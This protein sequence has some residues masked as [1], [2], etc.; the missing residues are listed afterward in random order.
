MNKK[1]FLVVAAVEIMALIMGVKTLVFPAAFDGTVIRPAPGEAAVSKEFNVSMEGMDR[2]VT[3]NVSPKTRSVTEIEQLFIEAKAEINSSFL[4][5]N[6]DMDHVSQNLNLKDSYANGA[7]SASWSFDN[8][9]VIDPGG[10]LKPE[11]LTETVPIKASV[12]LMCEDSQEIYSFYFLAT[13]LDIYSEEGFNY[14]IGKLLT[15]ADKDSL[16]SDRL[17]LPEFLSEKKL[18]WS[19][20]KNYT[21][22]QLALFGIAVGI[23]LTLGEKEDEKKKEKERQK[24]LQLDY[25]DIVSALSLYVGAGIGLKSAAERIAT[26]YE[27]SKKANPGLMRPGYEG[28]VMLCREIRDG[29]G[30]LESYKTFGRR[31]GHKDYRKLSIL[32]V[33]NLRKGTSNLLEQLEKEEHQAFEERKTRAKIAGEEASTKLLLPMMG[34]LGIVIVVMIFPAMQGMSI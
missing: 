33:Q 31:M 28:I 30:E 27:A 21:W 34:L 9:S 11:N 23:A 15:K 29:K 6:L 13:P 26:D 22:I 32:L 16:E 25:P 20:R 14:Y 12:T 3:V 4:G 17:V 7:V 1:I 24:L 2:E 8:Y 19:S 10:R 5:E 18:S